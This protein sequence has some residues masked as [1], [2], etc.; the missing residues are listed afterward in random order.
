MIPEEVLANAPR[1]LTQ[2]QREF[3][4][5]NGYLCIERLIAE[6]WLERLRR[7]SQEFLDHSRR[8]T[9]SGGV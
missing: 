2:G 6:E 9:E 8:E 7:I 5:A 4:F 3:Y 1:V